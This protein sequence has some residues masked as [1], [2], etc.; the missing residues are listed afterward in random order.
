[1]KCCTKCGEEKDT[2]SFSVTKRNPDG[3]VKYRSSWCTPCRTQQNRER[4]GMERKVFAK[5]DYEAETKECNHCKHSLSFTEFSPSGRGSAGLSAY[6]KVCQKERYY[7]KEKAK[8]VTQ[9][10]RDKHRLRWRA[11]H[12]IN[13]FNRRSRITA[14]AD[15][16]VTDE[17]L[18]QVYATEYCYWCKQAT[19]EELRTLEHIIELSNGGSHSASNITM[20]CQ[21]CNS[22]RPNRGNKVT[23]GNLSRSNSIQ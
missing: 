16:T 9:R 17:F 4:L 2:T 13:Q 15:G 6:C 18:H 11:L 1:M 22:S 5:V 14:T 10:Y 3:S 7:D 20:A 8:V 12:R 21:P 19:P 23:D